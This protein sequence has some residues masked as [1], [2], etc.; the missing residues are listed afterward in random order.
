MAGIAS[1]KREPSFSPVCDLRQSS[2]I[3]RHELRSFLVCF[4]LQ[5]LGSLPFKWFS[6]LYVFTDEG[7]F[8]FVLISV[9]W[10]KLLRVSL[11]LEVRLSKLSVFQLEVISTQNS[12]R[13]G[14]G[15]ST[16]LRLRQCGRN[17]TVSDQALLIHSPTSIALKRLSSLPLPPCLRQF[18]QRPLLS[19]SRPSFIRHSKLMKRKRNKTFSRIR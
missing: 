7:G 14:R 11:R 2:I 13:K 12:S 15:L 3:N 9:F 17:L 10:G 19:I 5:S 16:R 6:V 18:R 4:K 1:I 8:Q